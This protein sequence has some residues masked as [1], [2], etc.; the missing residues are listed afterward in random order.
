[1]PIAAVLGG[2][3]SSGTSQASATYLLTEEGF[4]LLLEE[5]F[6]IIVP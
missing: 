2:T 3:S 4:Y 6:K 1:M 5:G